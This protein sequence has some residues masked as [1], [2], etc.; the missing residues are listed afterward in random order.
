MSQVNIYMDL[1]DVGKANRETN[2]DVTD[3]WQMW[4]NVAHAN[5]WWRACIVMD[6]YMGMEW[7][8]LHE[9]TM[10]HKHAHDMIDHRLTGPSEAHVHTY[11]WQT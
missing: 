8:Y 7:E 2:F 1:C 10:S 3:V 9:P 5:G 11:R 4:I 6:A